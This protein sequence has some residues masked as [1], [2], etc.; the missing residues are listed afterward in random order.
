MY[1]GP[2]Y[3][4]FYYFCVVKRWLILLLLGL[5][6]LLYA[7]DGARATSEGPCGNVPASLCQ[8]DGETCSPL[9]AP[10]F[11]M[12]GSSSNIQGTQAGKTRLPVIC[13]EQTAYQAT[14]IQIYRS[15]LLRG[16]PRSEGYL[17]GR[18][19]DRFLY[20]FRKIVI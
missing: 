11:A 9:A 5:M 19:C 16:V 15:A 13:L 3:G 14:R 10:L 4:I 7:A 2:F 8:G 18:P 6:P 20:P 1:P 12:P 17:T